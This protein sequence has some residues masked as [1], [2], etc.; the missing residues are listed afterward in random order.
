MQTVIQKATGNSGSEDRFIELFCD[1][2]GAD[3]GQYVYLQYPMVDIY[4]R[5]RTID[6]AVNLP[7]GKVAIEVDGNTWH[8][9]GIVSTE[10]YHDDLLK[11][12]S[13][14]YE[15][16]RVYRWTSAQ[17]DKSPERVKDE[18]VTFLGQSPLFRYIED[19]L[20]PQQGETI[21]LMDHQEEALENLDSMR[22]AHKTIALLFHATGTGKTVTAVSDAKR[23]GKR[24]L[25]IAHRH[26]L[27]DQ[28][29]KTFQ[30]IWPEVSAGRY[31]G[32][33]REDDRFV[34]CGTIQSISQNL[35][36]FNPDD[37]GYLIIDE[38]HHGTADTYRRIMSY[39]H[40]GFTL[41]LTA[42]PERADGEDLLT[43]F[44]N[45]AHKLDL[46]TAVELD[47]LVPVRC[48]RIRTN[49][50]MHDVRISG[51]K[52]N[53]QDL[54]STIRVPGRNQLIV[55][56]YC[57]YV[58]DKPTVVFCASVKHAEEIAELFQQAGINAMCISGG[59]KATERK[60]ILADY[61]SGKLP[62]LCACDLLNEGWDSPHTQV[63]FMARPTMSKTIYVQQLGRG[64]RKSPGKDFLMVFDF[65]DNTNMFNVAYSIHRI[66]GIS[67]YVAGGLVLGTKHGMKMDMDMFRQGQK[68]E[69]LVDYPIHMA[70]YETI[71]LFNWQE[72]AKEMLSQIAFTQ[73]VNVQSETIE[74]YIRDGKIVPDMEVP[75][76]EHRSFKF[77]RK[78]TVEKY[79]KIY[80]WTLITKSN[81]KE[82]FLQM[83]DTMTMS[84]SYK[85]VFMLAFLDSMNDAGEARLEDV[86]RS[87]AAFYEDRLAHGLPAEKKNCIFTKGGYS[88]KDVE[89][90]ILS[91]PFKRY[92]DMHVMHHSKYLGTLQFYKALV[93]QLTDEDYAF[94]RGTCQT[95]I[96]KY[97][98]E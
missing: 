57:E 71:D 33:I 61:E 23:F 20:P 73:M 90:L 63:L 12:N 68:P 60:Q 25:F 29:I 3:K 42:T 98:Q 72:Q 38:C 8:Q 51:F 97:F 22:K 69:V 18:L 34:V 14:I 96:K 41:G 78:S 43:V 76:S 6:F 67:E 55:D 87:F 15:G 94:I 36:D 95:A 52:Y 32:S 81:M 40:P 70:E 89:R 77:F 59:T 45:V 7:D 30:K 84:Y 88:Q 91:M 48:I 17:I 66:L 47:T 83:V 26:E 50:D 86:A 4:G 92:E 54:E 2:F 31:E 80:G 28:A 39:F 19:A 35:D 85:P 27:V 79:A 9:P 13:M 93:R 21:E 82:I 11:Q 44:Q 1:A 10:K 56:T 62:V 53:S 65:V 16:W 37:F 24:T 5:H 46:K 75:V 49:I 64:M 74:R 58:K